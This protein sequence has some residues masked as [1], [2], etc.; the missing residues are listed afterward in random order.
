MRPNPAVPEEVWESF[1]TLPSQRLP[2]REA[3]PAR[4][5]MLLAHELA[6]D[7]LL[8]DAGKAAYA[9]LFS[10]LDAAQTRYAEKLEAA[11]SSVLVV[12]GQTLTADLKG[13]QKS[14]NQFFEDAD[15]PV[16]EAAY[17]R[18]AR[19]APRADLCKRY[20]ER[21]AAQKPTADDPEDALMQ[22]HADIAALGLVPTKTY[23]DAEAAKLADA[24][25]AKHR[26]PRPRACRRSAGRSTT[27]SSR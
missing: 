18:Q 26:V 16:V 27:R 15:Y 25:Q 20:A 17:R 12:E 2:Q 10:V 13:K 8:P 24:W 11:R 9:E 3:K 23:L 6:A 4:R 21:L 22:A 19:G 1:V 5:L 7:G 14:L